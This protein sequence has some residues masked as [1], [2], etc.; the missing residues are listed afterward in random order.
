M[1]AHI[2]TLVDAVKDIGKAAHDQ[3]KHALEHGDAIPGYALTEGRVVRAWQD[4]ATVAPALLRLGLMRDDAYERDR[5]TDRIAN[6]R[7]TAACVPSIQTLRAEAQPDDS[8]LALN[9]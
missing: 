1:L 5:R 3:A 9:E 6:R 7:P 2:L 4:E 8:F